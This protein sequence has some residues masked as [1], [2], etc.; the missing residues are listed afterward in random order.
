MQIKWL[1]HSTFE[2]SDG[3]TRVLIDPFLK[4]NNPKAT[5]TADEVDP[6]HILLTHGHTDHIADAIPVAKRTGAPVVAHTELAHWIG[7]QGVEEDARGFPLLGSGLEGESF[8]QRI[9][10]AEL[11]VRGLFHVIRSHTPNGW[12]KMTKGRILY[13]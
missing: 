3:D 1:G 6:T 2:L 12:R 7:E 13:K 10:N 8:L 9:G 5:V 4:P 11:E